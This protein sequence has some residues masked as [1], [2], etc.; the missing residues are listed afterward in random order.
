MAKPL[1][2]FGGWL[3]AFYIYQW[4]CVLILAMYVLS[5]ALQLF[6]PQI[7]SSVL[8]NMIK[9]LHSFI[10][11]HFILK[12]IKVIKIKEPNTPNSII[13][14]M[15]WI[16]IF[17]FI[18]GIGTGILIYSAS[19][20]VGLTVFS[21]LAKTALM[22]IIFYLI[23]ASYFRKSKRV[24]AY[25]G[26]NAGG[27]AVTMKKIAIFA[28]LL[29]LI[30]YN[31]DLGQ[32]PPKNGIHKEYFANGKL[33]S[34]VNYKSGK[35]EGLQRIYYE[36][37]NLK[38]EMNWKNGKKNGVAKGYYESGELKDVVESKNNQPHGMSKHYYMDGSLKA[39]ATWLNGKMIENKVYPIPGKKELDDAIR[40]AQE[41]LNNN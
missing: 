1:N 22:I 40:K 25:Y 26:K 20:R 6:G 18:F 7:E 14:Y 30:I 41:W 28:I 19:A 31:V 10:E 3:K 35:T 32:E 23:W 9:L 11:V 37:G 2:E 16:V 4:F 5:L 29:L 17:A 8:L 34:E 39:E 27:G 38:I 15:K 36:N 21:E 33:R 13:L 12:I 24:C